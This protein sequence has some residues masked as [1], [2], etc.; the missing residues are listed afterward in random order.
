M[1][2]TYPTFVYIL[3][4]LLGV[5]VLVINAWMDLTVAVCAIG[6]G[7]FAYGVNRLIGEWRVTHD[8]EYARQLEIANQDERLA[9]IAD[10]SRSLTLI[11]TVISL[12]VLGIVLQSI[13]MKSYG[14]LC[15]YIMCGI[16][17]LYFII[18][19][20]LSRRY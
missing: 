16:S 15:L 20:V 6:A 5:S 19:K 10:K 2:G 4:T 3:I 18:Y 7:L 8:P 9:Y 13:G 11:I 14:F 17:V 12:A 1:K